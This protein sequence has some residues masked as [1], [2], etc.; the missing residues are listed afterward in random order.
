MDEAAIS[1]LQNEITALESLLAG[2]KRQLEAAQAAC[3]ETASPPQYNIPAVKFTIMLMRRFRYYPV[4]TVN[5]SR[6]TNRWASVEE[7]SPGTPG[8]NPKLRLVDTSEYRV[9]LSGKQ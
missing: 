1:S 9:K 3:S 6:D 5:G 7:F 8:K 2:K 4:C